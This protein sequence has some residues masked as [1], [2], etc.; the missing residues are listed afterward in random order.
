MKTSP[1]NPAS[2]LCEQI[3]GKDC[4]RWGDLNLKASATDDFILVSVDPASSAFA[5][6]IAGFYFKSGSGNVVLSVDG[7]AIFTLTTIS[8]GN[9]HF[10][11]NIYSVHGNFICDY[12][13]Y[14]SA[15]VVF[16]DTTMF[17][18]THVPGS[19]IALRLDG[20][21]GTGASDTALLV[22]G[23]GA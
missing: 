21:F 4:G 15:G 20:P 10:V 17:A 5:M 1:I 22:F 23:G 2:I 8:N 13:G 18:K 9:G 16:E 14:D 7:T 12:R 19:P 6:T 11:A 3:E